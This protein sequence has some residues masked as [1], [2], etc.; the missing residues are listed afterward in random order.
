MI[1]FLPFTPD[2]AAVVTHKYILE[3]KN[4]VRQRVSSSGRQLV[5]NIILDIR[6]DGAICGILAS[7][8]YDSDQGARSLKAAVDSRVE[9]ELVKAYLEEDG[10]IQDQ[11]PLVRYAVDITRAGMVSVFKAIE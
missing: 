7:E 5:G 9:A 11:Q 6:R 1:P 8:G 10:Q 3:L 2:E 4:R